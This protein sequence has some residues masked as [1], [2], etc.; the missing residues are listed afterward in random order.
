ML[1]EAA[2]AAGVIRKADGVWE[3][4]R[5]RLQV[6]LQKVIFKGEDID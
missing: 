4:S 6:T 3:K 1:T 5:R 2:N